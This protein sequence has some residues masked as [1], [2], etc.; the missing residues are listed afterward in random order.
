MKDAETT[1]LELAGKKEVFDCVDVQG[2][3]GWRYQ[4]A[5]SYLR[6]LERK[7]ALVTVYDG[8]KKM[9]SL[10]YNIAGEQHG[11]KKQI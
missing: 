8:K 10:A 5:A 4:K 1:I 9:Y 6:V 2:A 7:K 3:T 11:N